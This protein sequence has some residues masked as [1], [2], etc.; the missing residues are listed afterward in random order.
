[1]SVGRAAHQGGVI[2]RCDYDPERRTG[3]YSRRSAQKAIIGTSLAE[4]TPPERVEG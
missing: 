1:M 3:D 4:L 2:V